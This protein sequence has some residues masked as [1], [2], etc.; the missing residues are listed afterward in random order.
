M[1][2]PKVE[3]YPIEALRVIVNQKN[4]NEKEKFYNQITK[5]LYNKMEQTNI[6]ELITMIMNEKD[7]F[8]RD[9]E[10]ET[11]SSKLVNYKGPISLDSLQKLL[12]VFPVASTWRLA[13][14][15]TH[16][17]IKM[18]A[19]KKIEQILDDYGYEKEGEIENQKRRKKI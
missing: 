15:A 12:L 2:K 8:F 9:I 18:S 1:K 17:V 4:E 3:Q 16:P 11:L 10:C 7:P 14:E 13:S 5:P 6:R 19:I